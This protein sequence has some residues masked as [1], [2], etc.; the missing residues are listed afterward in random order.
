MKIRGVHYDVGTAFEAAAKDS[1]AY[2]LLGYYSTNTR[3]DGR[4]RKAV[5]PLVAFLNQAPW[6]CLDPDGWDDDSAEWLNSDGSF[7]AVEIADL[8]IL[9]RDNISLKIAEISSGSSRAVSLQ[10][11]T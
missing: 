10:S 9:G 11:M 1:S 2:Y 6:E 7:E 4:Y 5:A 8:L 3:L